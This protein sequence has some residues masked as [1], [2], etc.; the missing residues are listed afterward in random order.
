MR[1]ES[2]SSEFSVRSLGNFTKFFKRR[3]L[4]KNNSQK[5]NEINAFKN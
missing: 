3:E 1:T 4:N 5:I 2:R